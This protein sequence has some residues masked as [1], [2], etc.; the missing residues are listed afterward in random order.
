MMAAIESA[1]GVLNAREIALSSK[2]LIGI[3]F[4]AED[5]VTDMRTS[6]SPDGSELFLLEV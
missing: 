5:Y 3:A 6:R 2:R 1:V 4:G